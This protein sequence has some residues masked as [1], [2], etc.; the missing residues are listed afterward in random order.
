MGMLWDSVCAHRLK[1][2]AQLENLQHTFL[3][4]TLR[5]SF[6]TAASSFR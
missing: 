4:S 6:C 3:A 5:S 1:P 2:A